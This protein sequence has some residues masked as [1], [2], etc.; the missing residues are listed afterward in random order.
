MLSG[1]GQQGR[2]LRRKYCS[3]HKRRLA[4]GPEGGVRTVEVGGWEAEERRTLV[5][6]VNSSLRITYIEM[7]DISYGYS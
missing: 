1:E 2:G 5:F 6:S 7:S 4:C 3:R